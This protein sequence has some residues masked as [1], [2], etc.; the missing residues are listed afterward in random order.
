MC[1]KAITAVAL[2]VWWS[3]LV[4][5]VVVGRCRL[6][7]YR[8]VWERARTSLGASPHLLHGPCLHVTSFLFRGAGERRG[9]GQRAASDS[10][11]RLLALQSKATQFPIS[12]AASSMQ[13]DH[14]QTRCHHGSPMAANV[15]AR[16]RSD[17]N[18][19]PHVAT[20]RTRSCT[21]D[22]VQTGQEG[23]QDAKQA[24]QEA[25]G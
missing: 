9:R 7:S 8:I 17:G 2:C 23:L 24:T 20:G 10:Q 12:A 4:L 21:V 16:P 25:L 13:S 1:I 6:L 18:A 11:R 3:L 5:L 15:Y 19:G 14:R 22:D